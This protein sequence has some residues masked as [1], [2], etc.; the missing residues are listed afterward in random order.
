MYVLLCVCVQL[1]QGSGSSNEALLK[2]TSKSLVELST[3]QFHTI[4][5]GLLAIFTELPVSLACMCVH[6]FICVFVFMH[7]CVFV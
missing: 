5:S 1:P 4:L 3:V 6:L 2:Q 7:V